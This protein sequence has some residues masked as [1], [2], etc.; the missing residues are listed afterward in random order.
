MVC[1]TY[2]EID[3]VSIHLLSICSWEIKSVLESSRQ[4]DSNDYL[5]NIFLYT[6]EINMQKCVY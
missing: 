5:F 3:L 6:G 2:V 4:D 1:Q